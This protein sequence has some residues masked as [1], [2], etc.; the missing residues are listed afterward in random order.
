M[1][2]CYVNTTHP[3]FINGHKA[4]AIVQERLNANKPQPPPQ[5]PKRAVNNNKD[6]DVDMKKEEP[7]FFG[8]FWNKAKGTPQQPAKKGA[9]VMDAVS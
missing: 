3:D 2:A 5:D 7:S 9:A 6:L 4:M 8:S 1:Q